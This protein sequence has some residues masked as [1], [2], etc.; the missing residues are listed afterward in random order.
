MRVMQTFDL[1]LTSP[2]KP[3]YCTCPHHGTDQC[4]CQMIVLLI[5]GNEERPVSLILHG[6]DGQT[7][8]AIADDPRQRADVK[9]IT[10]IQQALEIKK[11]AVVS[12]N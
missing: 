10:A 12:Q 6:N 7:W 2:L 1:R 8:L 5:Y 9:L 3:G 11:L 4:D